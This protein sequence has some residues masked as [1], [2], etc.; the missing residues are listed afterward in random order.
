MYDQHLDEAIALREGTTLRI[1]KME[2]KPY[3]NILSAEAAPAA[4]GESASAFYP[5]YSSY[6]LLTRV[7]TLS[8]LFTLQLTTPFP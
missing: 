7:S 6:L 3:T 5:V 4:A 1:P 2:L 8:P